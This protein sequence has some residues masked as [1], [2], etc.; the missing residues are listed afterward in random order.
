VGILIYPRFFVLLGKV[1]SY[2]AA[3]FKKVTLLF[4]VLLAPL[5]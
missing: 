5:Y 2:G 3:S 1:L 4:F